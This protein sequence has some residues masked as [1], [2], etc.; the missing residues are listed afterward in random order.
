[1]RIYEI[2]F[3]DS[4]EMTYRILPMDE[5]TKM[6][7]LVVNSVLTSGAYWIGVNHIIADIDFKIEP[8]YLTMKYINIIRRELNINELLD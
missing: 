5:F 4:N 1:M 6:E 2:L 3:N 8:K 7:S